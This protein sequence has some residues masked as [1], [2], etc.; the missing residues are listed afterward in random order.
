MLLYNLN[1]K[2]GVPSVQKPLP[3]E[4]VTQVV[5]KKTAGD[6]LQGCGVGTIGVLLSNK[7]TPLPRSGCTSLTY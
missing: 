2:F 4:I 7:G 3:L 5:L 1:N 6:P